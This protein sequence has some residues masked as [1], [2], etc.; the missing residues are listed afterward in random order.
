LL[1]LAIFH[2]PSTVPAAELPLTLREIGRAAVMNNP[3]L[4]TARF[5]P[6]LAASSANKAHAIYDPVLTAL[7]ENKGNDSKP[8]PDSQVT[9]SSRSWDSNLSLA[10]LLQ[11]GATASAGISSTWQRDYN[12]FKT[13]DSVAPAFS[14]SVSQPLLKSAGKEMTER[15]IT[16]AD[17]DRKSSEAD[18]YAQM[19][20]VAAKASTQFLAVLK[21]RE[22]LGS[23]KAS[24]EAARRL[25]V[26]NE[27]RVRAGV[28]API[29][30][31]DSEL[32]VATREVDLL[33]AD[34]AVRDAEDALRFLVHA[35][36]GDA[37]G[38]GEP[39]AE[40]DNVYVAEDP[41][42]VA[43]AKRPELA[44]AR[45]ALLSEDFNVKVARNQ[46][47]PDLSLKGT[48]GVTGM[49][50]DTVKGTTDVAEMRYPFWT[51]GVQLAFPIRNG[52]ARAD[53]QS[54]RL[55]AS[56]VRSALS[57]LEDSIALEV[58]NAIRTID[59]RFRQIAVARKGVQVAESRL[60][61]FV[62]R[63]SLGMATTRNVLDAETD[64]TAAR[65]SLTLAKADYQSALVELWRSTGELPE[66]EGIEVTL[67]EITEAAW[68]DIR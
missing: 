30:L 51:V 9:T 60:A 63:N 29:D 23:R 25:H 7:L 33:T 3:D 65:E 19:L 47:L 5:V 57:G 67:N 10:T 31:L 66:K 54:S 24:V 44:K 61:S 59:T 42:R 27:A 26:E 55:R 20:S 36:A 41:V 35:P 34:K 64:L 22:S 56:Q 49:G 16:S 58:N 14:V 68:R 37:F 40:P 28:L 45:L 13:T 8:F 11:T 46:L 39:L 52:S 4:R 17:F 43:F 50:S 6:A 21:A 2:L 62:K 1:L 32:G 53:Y 18:W 15:G 48:A 12:G 38:P